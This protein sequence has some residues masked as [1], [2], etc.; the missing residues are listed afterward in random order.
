M[1][2]LG[3]ACGLAFERLG[4]PLVA[5]CGLA[6]GAGT[7]TLALA[8][9][10]QAAR[11]SA[12]PVPPRAAGSA[13]GDPAPRRRLRELAE[14]YVDRLVLVP[15]VPALARGEDADGRLDLALAAIATALRRPA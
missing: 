5:V 14:R 9:A 7:T 8:L 12:L 13:T 2:S 10:R 15:H 4:G 6:G 3:S 11:E 1:A